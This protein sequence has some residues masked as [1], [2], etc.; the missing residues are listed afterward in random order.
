MGVQLPMRSVAPWR[1]LARASALGSGLLVLTSCSAET[2]DE[3]KRV[4]MPE[5][6]TEEAWQI[7]EFWQWSWIALMVT[8][9]LVWGLMLYAAWRYRRR[10]DDDVPVQTRYNLPLEIFY[11]IAPMIMILV[12]FSHTVR[13]QHDLTEV[14][15]NP[16]HTV[17][18]VGQQWSWT[19]NYTDEDV[20]EGKN[21]FEFGTASYIPTL[22]LPVDESVRFEL[23]SPD[24]I[25][26]FW[27]T[28]FLYKEDIIPGRVNEFVVTPDKEGTYVGKCAE[29]CGSYHSRML[30]N[31]EVV[32]REEY[33]AYLQ[34][35]IDRGFWSDEVLL[36]NKETIT[37]A[38]LETTA[39]EGGTE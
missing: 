23:R 26:S 28:G 30:F 22:V 38:G 6:A 14:D 4:A 39:P 3:W 33:D 35:Q 24:V 18:V 21:V 19:F 1:R 37:Q 13:I 34:D 27:V 36:G 17:V 5:P 10:H 2:T 25:H 7:L 12:L 9:A 11:T 32:S 8:G 20:A 31:V 15:P 29:L 16:D